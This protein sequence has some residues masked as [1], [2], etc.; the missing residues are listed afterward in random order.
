MNTQ[1]VKIFRTESIDHYF[2]CIPEDADDEIQV[3]CDLLSSALTALSL[4][5]V[6]YESIIELVT[7]IWP[8]AEE[9][10]EQQTKD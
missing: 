3:G 6:E 9:F 10:S 7:K 1:Q 4:K 5:G 2:R 8:I